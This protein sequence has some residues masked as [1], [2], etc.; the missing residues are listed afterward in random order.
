MK[1]LL[2]SLALSLLFLT[3]AAFA[4][5]MPNPA[6]ERITDAV[7]LSDVNNKTN[8]TLAIEYQE[9][10]TEEE[11]ANEEVYEKS[12]KQV[13]IAHPNRNRHFETPL[14]LPLRKATDQKTRN[15]E[16]PGHFYGYLTVYDPNNEDGAILRIRIS[17][18]LFT[19]F[20]PFI[21]AFAADTRINLTWSPNLPEGTVKAE[22]EQQEK[23]I[24]IGRELSEEEQVEEW[25]RNPDKIELLETWSNHNPFNASSH[26]LLKP[27]E[28]DTYRISLTIEGNDLEGSHIDV[29]AQVNSPEE[30]QKSYMTQEN[31]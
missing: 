14:S 30:I 16:D 11:A 6:P 23:L 9:Y 22:K 25:L 13:M 17:R 21:Q 3:S 15:P 5:E 31:E 18:H 28:K 4:M 12:L 24:S 20:F 27:G 7:Y 29:A 8:K 26:N 2:Q 10:L 19:P 1:L